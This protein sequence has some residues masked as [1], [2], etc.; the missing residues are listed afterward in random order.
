MSAI[1][2]P[3]IRNDPRQYDELAGEWW[4]ADGDFA[5]LQWIARA[6]AELIPPPPGPGA[7]LLDVGCGGGLLSPYVRGYRHVGV[8]QSA[9]SLAVAAEHGV[10]TVQADVTA[11]PF[12]DQSFDVVVAGEIFEHVE[13]LEAAVRESTRVL[14]AG[15]TFVCDTIN[16]T[17]FSSVGIIT[18]AER[19]PGGPPLGCHDERLFVDPRRL[20]TLCARHGVELRVWGLRPSIREYLGFLAG[21]RRRVKMVRTRYLG[22]LYQGLGHKRLR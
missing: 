17:R 13:D 6:R 1:A 22:G 11:L 8:D 7:T 2:R 21:R 15:G 4:K 9:A 12:K 20:Q 3:R 10:E 5:A 18:I 14:R 16:R 19:L